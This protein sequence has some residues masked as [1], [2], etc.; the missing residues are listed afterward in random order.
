MI[1]V[2][3]VHGH[4]V[5]GYLAGWYSDSLLILVEHPTQPHDKFLRKI[6]LRSQVTDFDLLDD[7]TYKTEKRY[8]EMEEIIAPFRT[9]M[10][11][12]LARQQDVRKVG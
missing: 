4:S 8:S 3:M 12:V 2:R 10:H 1:N 6:I 5:C 9:A 11:R 7:N